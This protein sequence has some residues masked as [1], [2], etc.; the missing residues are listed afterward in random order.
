MFAAFF[1]M[2]RMTL[3]EFMECSTVNRQKCGAFLSVLNLRLGC[4]L[5]NDEA[6]SLIQLVECDDFRA[7]RVASEKLE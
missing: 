5:F 4:M 7:R 2:H 3:L 6:G 1:D